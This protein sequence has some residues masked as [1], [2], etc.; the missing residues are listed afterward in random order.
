MK[1]RLAGFNIDKSLIDTLP[2][3]DIA[4]PEVISAA[5][6]RISRSAKNV[7]ELRQEA[8][9]EIRKSRSSNSKIIFEM[10]H[11][12][13]AE[14]AVFNIDIIG[15]SRYLAEFVQ[16]SRLV[17]FTEKSQRYVTLDGDFVVPPEIAAHDD[18]RSQ[19][20]ELDSGRSTSRQYACVSATTAQS[21][22]RTVCCQRASTL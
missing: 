17:S 21:R 7:S 19:Y 2:N 4:T 3:Q 5:Y 14:H 20:E 22:R 12:S 16:Q 1:V 18:L 8:L 10:G 11:S 6:A 15:I 13:I 9:H